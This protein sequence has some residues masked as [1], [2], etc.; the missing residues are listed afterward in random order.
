MIR[1]QEAGDE[2]HSGTIA[3]RCPK[4]VID[5]RGVQQYELGRKQHFT[6]DGY[7]S[8]LVIAGANIGAAVCQSNV[9]SSH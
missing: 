4:A 3:V 7:I 9:R 2:N 5:G 6:P 1:T 8:F